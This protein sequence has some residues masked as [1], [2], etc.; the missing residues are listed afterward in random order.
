M[1]ESLA[2]N[3]NFSKEFNPDELILVNSKA[4][5][6]REDDNQDKSLTSRVE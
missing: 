2:N 1:N 3:Q 5:T 6:T 4:M